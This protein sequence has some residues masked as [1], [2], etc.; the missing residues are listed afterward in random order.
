MSKSPVFSWGTLAFSA[1]CGNKGASHEKYLCCCSH[2]SRVGFFAVSG[3]ASD[4]SA[5]RA[6]DEFL[7]WCSSS[8]LL[9]GRSLPARFA[10]IAKGR[11]AGLP[12]KGGPE[13]KQF[14]HAIDYLLWALVIV[15]GTALFI[16][17]I[18]RHIA[19]DFPRFVLLLGFACVQSIVLVPISFLL[20]YKV[21]FYTFYLSSGIEA[22]LLVLVAAEIFRVVFEPVS[23]LP[24][25]TLSRMAG[26]VIAVAAAAI[27]FIA[28]KP[29]EGFGHESA[30]LNGAR[31][32]VEVIVCSAFWLLAIYSR[33]MGL[34]WQSR[35]ADILSGF[36]FY[37][38][39][40]LMT[41]ALVWFSP[42]VYAMSISRI[43]A[44][45]YLGGLCFWWAALRHQAP[46]F[47]P[48]T[49]AQLLLLKAY[50]EELHADMDRLDALEIQQEL[51]RALPP[52]GPQPRPRTFD[53]L[54][55]VL[56]AVEFPEYEPIS[57]GQMLALRKGILYNCE[58]LLRFVRDQYQPLVQGMDKLGEVETLK[59]DA[60]R[61]MFEC[62]KVFFGFSRKARR[63]R[64]QRL[65]ALYN[66]VRVAA[67]LLC[68][69]AQSYLVDDIAVAL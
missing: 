32:A 53:E 31:M 68:F 6:E 1:T 18:R 49:R 46:T 47:A 30:I 4:I 15:S 61:V 55:M 28:W 62:R 20:S 9:A 12:S 27:V 33:F 23:A 29:F 36:L 45:A 66:E 25:H 67:M 57:Y 17:A 3:R 43:E 11:P 35:V 7:L 8:I 37:L 56:K 52:P 2:G 14:L 63:K 24:A 59:E 41:L 13:M 39:I 19:A 51:T 58:W 64:M 34:R 22:A 44:I 38:T 50:I 65:A 16:G 26:T 54:L 42:K 10:T 40:Q 69:G 48:V 5:D 21:Y 60:V